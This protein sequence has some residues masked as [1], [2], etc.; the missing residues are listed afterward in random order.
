MAEALKALKDELL[1]DCLVSFLAD[2][3]ND[4]EVDY[5]SWQRQGLCALQKPGKGKD[6]AEPNN[7]RGICLAEI[8][9]KLQCFMISTK[10]LDQIGEM[11]DIGIETQCGCVPGKGC[12]Y[13]LFSMKS[14]L[15]IRKQH[16]QDTWAIFIDLA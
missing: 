11:I 2:Y 10:L 7:W 8:P 15:Q 1:R 16:G 12:A 5:E 9:A 13:A 6:Y 4:L 14:A 3:W